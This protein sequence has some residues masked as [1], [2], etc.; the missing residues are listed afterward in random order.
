MLR[1]VV[2]QSLTVSSS[3]DQKEKHSNGAGLLV[4]EEE[5]I[6]VGSTLLFSSMGSRKLLAV[7]QQVTW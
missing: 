1:Y 7:N 6:T 5:R 3:K 2:Y 4:E